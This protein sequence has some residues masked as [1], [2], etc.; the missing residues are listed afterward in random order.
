MSERENV[1]PK[2]MCRRLMLATA[3]GTLCLASSAHADQEGYIDYFPGGIRLEASA[4]NPTT[5]MTDQDVL[6]NHNSLLLDA[7]NTAWN[8]VGKGITSQKLREQLSVG[9]RFRSGVTL[10]NVNPNMA[11]LS[12]LR[13]IDRGNNQIGLKA[14]F[15]GNTIRFHSTTPSF[16][17]GYA[18]PSF[19]VKY[20]LELKLELTVPQLGQSLQF[21][22]LEA[23]V[24]N[25]VIEPTNAAAEIGV[26][27]SNIWAFLSGQNLVQE[28]T[29]TINSTRQN[30]QGSANQA[31]ERLTNQELD[32]LFQK[33][34]QLS[35]QGTTRIQASIQNQSQVVL[36]THF[37]PPDTAFEGPGSISGRV[38]WPK[39]YGYSYGRNC[40][41]ISITAS[42]QHVASQ[43]GD[44]WRRE[45]NVGRLEPQP[46]FAETDTHYECHYTLIGLPRGIPL[47][48]KVTADVNP[49]SWVG[50]S[51]YGGVGNPS[52]WSGEITLGASN[53]V[54]RR[55]SIFSTQISPE[56]LR[57]PISQYLQTPNPAVLRPLPARG[58]WQE[59]PN[60]RLRD[61]LYQHT[62][63]ALERLPVGVEAVVRQFSVSNI[64]FELTLATA[65]APVIR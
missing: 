57:A 54:Q 16:L 36:S 40:H 22:S 29:N 4:F 48:M 20:D 31:L 43:S 47:N 38:Y 13:A 24:M 42:A 34:Q 65:P 63:S 32:N 55:D 14:I 8:E 6:L 27:L 33:A 26:G 49:A 12:E 50:G 7:I 61:S 1:N 25:A 39:S 53:P 21:N 30:F 19:E 18:D 59:S 3:L 17:G 58:V 2:K 60:V 46:V 52:G 41:F 44:L 15:R 9:D 11:G 51:V 10:Y 45:R 64:D 35:S 56:M 23:R 37:N 28:I 5:R 62:G